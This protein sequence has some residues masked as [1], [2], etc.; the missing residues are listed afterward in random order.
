MSTLTITPN[1]ATVNQTVQISGTG[2][3]TNTKTQVLLDNVVAP[4]GLL[5]TTKNGSFSITATVSATPKTQTVV[6]QQVLQGNTWSTVYTTSL[7]VQ[8]GSTA[9]TAPQNLTA[10][11]GNTTAALSWAAP[12]SNGGSAITGYKVYKNSILLTTVAGLSYTATGLTNG[13]QYGFEVSAVNSIGEGPRTPVKF[14]T[15]VAAATAPSVPLSLS[16]VAGNTVASLSWSPP[17]SNGGASITGYKVYRNTVLVTTVTSTS[18]TDTGLTN[19]TPYSYAVSAVNSV[20]EGPKTSPVTVTPVSVIVTC[21]SSLQTA[22][23]NVAI[24]GTVD[25]TG[26]TFREAVTISKPMTLRGGTI[27]GQNARFGLRIRANDVTVVGTS[28]INALLGSVYEGAVDVRGVSRFKFTGTVTHS[29]SMGFWIEGGTGHSVDANVSGH[30]QTG[31]HFHN[32]TNSTLK[33]KSYGNGANADVG[34]ES[35][36]AKFVLVDGVSAID[37]ESYSNTGP[38]VWWDNFI[39]ATAQRVN[40]HDNTWP[41][42]FFEAGRNGFAYDNVLNNNWVGQ[43]P[44]LDIVHTGAIR[45]NAC[46]DLTIQRNTLTNGIWGVTLLA[47]DRADATGT[48]SGLPRKSETGIVVTGNTISGMIKGA[49]NVYSDYADQ[50]IMSSVISPNTVS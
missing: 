14:V 18:Y 43:N 44:D 41:G 19:G 33:G 8:A 11:A 49:I 10:V 13:T 4:V 27:D 6:V 9:P 47:Q 16:G 12:L 31:V 21:P 39:N 46:A 7:V 50:S 37:F 25:V 38:G 42:I 29:N 24:G 3:D 26:C 5:R 45:V 2:F 1:P 48:F 40:A 34:N 22:V 15:P 30:G 35:G 32:L 36:G 23:N 20:G 17:S 28:V